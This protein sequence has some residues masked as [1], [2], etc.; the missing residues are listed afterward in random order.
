MSSPTEGLNIMSVPQITVDMQ[1]IFGSRQYVAT[2]HIAGKRISTLMGDCEPSAADIESAARRIAQKFG[3]RRS[4]YVPANSA[5][6]EAYR[7]AWGN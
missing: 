7:E 2:L 1:S 6:P 4:N 3:N 5:D